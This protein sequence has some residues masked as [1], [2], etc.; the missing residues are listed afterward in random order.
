MNNDDA[1]RLVDDLFFTDDG[2]FLP[3]LD[4]PGMSLERPISMATASPIF[5]G[6]TTAA[7]R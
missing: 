5:F 1:I 2:A 7:C 4:P 3:S 6:R